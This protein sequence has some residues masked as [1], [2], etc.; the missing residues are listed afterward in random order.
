MECYLELVFVHMNQPRVFQK[1]GEKGVY[2]TVE[3]VIVGI[4]EEPKISRF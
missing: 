3:Q 1:D 2:F 4:D